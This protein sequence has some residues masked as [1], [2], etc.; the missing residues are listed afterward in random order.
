MHVQS[1]NLVRLG[2]PLL[3]HPDPEVA[4]Q[5]YMLLLSAYG[6]GVAASLRRLAQDGDAEVRR[7]AQLA[8]QGVA[9]GSALAAEIPEVTMHIACLGSLRAYVGGKWLE[10]RAWSPEG[11]GRAG[12]QKVQ[13]VF[14]FLVH[15]GP[16]G[17]TRGVM[18]AAVWGEQASSSSLARTLTTLRQALDQALGQDFAERL[19]VTIGDHVRLDAELYETDWQQFERVYA[20]AVDTEHANGLRAAAPL[21]AQAL[22][23][24]A[25][26]YMGDV[27][28]GSGWMTA[29]REL[30]SSYCVIAAERLA[31]DAY[32]RGDYRRCVQVCL[33]ALAADPAID[34][35]VAWMLRAYAKLG[36]YGELDY[37]YHD[38]LRT[39]AMDT[40]DQRAQQDPVV[41]TYEEVI[42]SRIVND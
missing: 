5:A 27:L 31:E 3:T 19:L 40:S 42:R 36:N 4:R 41:R 37:A 24:Y 14:A 33:Q 15:T 20:R 22:E 17:T 34:D 21:Y 26:P 32:A 9:A 2:L 38:Y 23:L 13:A 29:R 11:G 8:L 7:Q 1:T 35:I 28:P 6:E 25:G 16:H 18:S 10:P 30:L 12:W 39:V